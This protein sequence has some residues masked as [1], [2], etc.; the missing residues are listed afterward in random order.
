MNK[1]EM[2]PRMPEATV[3]VP[4]RNNHALLIDTVDSLVA[5][6]VAHD[7]YEIVV[8]DDGSNPPI[9]PREGVRIVRHEWPRGLNAARN[10]GARAA[11]AELLCYVDDD[12]EAPP[13][14]LGE[15]IAGAGRHAD[16]WCF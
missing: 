7:R 6:E 12:I 13:Y 8:V 9:E 3:I 14:W 4:T 16:A 5:Q 15:L 10:S 1:P 11:R 2:A